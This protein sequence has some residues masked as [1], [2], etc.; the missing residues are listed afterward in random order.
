MELVLLSLLAFWGIQWSHA[1]AGFDT[2]AGENSVIQRGSRW[3]VSGYAVGQELV[4]LRVG[5]QRLELRPVGTRWSTE[6]DVPS[7]AAGRLDV[8]IEGGESRIVLVGDIWLCSGQSNM[9]MSVAKVAD[10]AE[11]LKGLDP[12]RLRVRKVLP[13]AGKRPVSFRPWEEATAANVRSFSAVCLAFGKAL[14]RRLGVPVGLIDASVGGSRI[15]A[16]ISEQRLPLAIAGDEDDPRQVSVKSRQAG[17]GFDKF[18]ASQ[19]A[20]LMIVPLTSAPIRGVLW[21]QGESNRFNAAHYADR[22]TLLMQDWRSLWHDESMPFVVIQ[23]PGVGSFDDSFDPLSPA[24]AVRE[25]QALAVQGDRFAV[26]VNTLDLGDT[27]L[28][29]RRKLALG[30]RAAAAADR[31]FYRRQSP[32]AAASRVA[33]TVRADTITVDLSPV[34]GCVRVSGPLYG[35]FVTGSDRMWHPA[36]AEL[37]GQQLSARS[38]SVPH[39]VALRYAWANRPP[40]P[41]HDCARDQPLPAFRTDDW[42][43]AR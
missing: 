15:E 18:R 26:A 38:Q 5:T 20:K 39:P 2:S 33:S 14:E 6:V 1:A 23:L 29:P 7:E 27:D 42:P 22:L 17:E 10:G 35:V 30:A 19:L 40:T 28:H 37:V 32:P 11:I 9:A 8:A 13:P 16:W 3:R 31:A 4:V 12:W 41:L 36:S 43:V 21:Y 24:A 25:A 34:S